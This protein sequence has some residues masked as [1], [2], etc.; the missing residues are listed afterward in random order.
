MPQTGENS[1]TP[2]T[3]ASLDCTAQLL[4]QH[5]VAAVRYFL[6]SL[7]S[8]ESTSYCLSCHRNGLEI[9]WHQQYEL[10]LRLHYRRIPDRVS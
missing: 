2:L 3:A 8:P 5:L 1:A 9:C 6:I 4:L 7:L 10:D